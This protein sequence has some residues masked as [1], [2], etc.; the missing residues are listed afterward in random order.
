MRIN[1]NMV[2]KCFVDITK[3]SFSTISSIKP[4]YTQL[5]IDGKFVDSAKGDTF[6][7][8]NPVNEEVI[9][10]VQR[11]GAEDVDRAV[12]AARKAFDHGPWRRFSATQRGE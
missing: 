12:E 10:E 7:T 6:A 1:K 9:T 4:K 3:R 11:A 2:L 8:V 5:L